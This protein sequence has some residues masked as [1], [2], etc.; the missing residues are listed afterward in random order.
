VYIA[1]LEKIDQTGSIGLRYHASTPEDSKHVLGKILTRSS[2]NL[3][4]NLG[5]FRKISIYF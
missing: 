2:K 1:I 3:R 4:F 5:F